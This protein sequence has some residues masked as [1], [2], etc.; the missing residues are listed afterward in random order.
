MSRS[1][2]G[3][4]V[5]PDVDPGG[6]ERVGVADRLDGVTREA[7]GQLVGESVGEDGPDCSGGEG[8]A[9]LAEEAV[10]GGGGADLG[11]GEGVLHGEDQVLHDQSEARAEQQY[12]KADDRERAVDVQR[13]HQ[14]RGH[15]RR[16]VS[17]DREHPDTDHDQAEQ[18]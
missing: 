13:G 11:G 15:V 2:L 16:Q 14:K 6:G 3:R 4:F 17:D 5:S 1:I 18:G 7:G 12:V 8:G 10:G 9:D